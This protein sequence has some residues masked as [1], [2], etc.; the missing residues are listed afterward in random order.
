MPP[1]TTTSKQL[2]K[3]V[4]AFSANC[5][6]TLS[7]PGAPPADAAPADVCPGCGGSKRGRGFTHAENCPE[8]AKRAGTN[9][10][11]YAKLE[12]G[13]AVPS[14]KMLEKIIKALS[15]KSSDVLPF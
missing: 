10:N 13:E 1:P 11:Y 7:L 4:D 12:R 2:S 8:V 15:I 6:T 3:R 14:L 9:T 5:T